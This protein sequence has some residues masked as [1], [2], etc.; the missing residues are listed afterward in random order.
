MPQGNI[1]VA[2][3]LLAA[4]FSCITDGV[5]QIER[6]GAEWIHFDVM[7]GSFVPN[8]TFGPQFIKD[9]RPRTTTSCLWWTWCWS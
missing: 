8:I 7:D 5:N 3:S 2:P 9:V 4:D 1:I 6:A